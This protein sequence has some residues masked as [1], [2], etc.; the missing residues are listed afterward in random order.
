VGDLGELASL[1]SV[2]VDVVDI[3]RC[4]DEVAGGNSVSD[5]VGVGVLGGCIEAEVSEVVEDQVDTDLV[6]L[7]GDQWESKTRV[8]AEPELERNIE[9][10]F[11]GAVADLVGGVWLASSAVI[12]AGLAALDNEVGE[13][14][15]VANHLGIAG[16]LACLLGEL[17]PDVEPLSIVLVNALTAD[18]ELDLLDEVVASPVEPAELSTRAVCREELNLWQSGLEVHAVDQVTISL[19]GAGDSLAKARRTVEWVLNGLHGEVSVATVNHL[20]KGN[21]RI[22]CQINVLGTISDKLHKSSSSHISLYLCQRKKI[23]RK[24]KRNPQPGTSE[25]L[26]LNSQ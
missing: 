13:L 26:N 15:D 22:T 11:W 7:E 10:I 17:I 24:E 19:N 8:A 14:R 6:V 2:E 12:V 20:E 18:L 5:D 9:S 4:R 25:F 3:E 23:W 21:L 16:L 1:I